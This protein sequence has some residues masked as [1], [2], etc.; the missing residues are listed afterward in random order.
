MD[1]ATSSESADAIA[2]K[3]EL[4]LQRLQQRRPAKQSRADTEQAKVREEELTE[5]LNRAKEQAD[6]G[7]VNEETIKALESFLSLEGCGWSAK[8]IQAALEMLRKTSV[9]VSGDGSQKSAFSFS[10]PKKPSTPSHRPRKKSSSVSSETSS[11]I[12]NAPSDNVIS[13]SNM[14]DETRLVAGENGNDIKLK[15]IK[16][17]K[18]SFAFR[19]STVHI[20]GLY[21][22][23][24]VFLPV[25]TSV[26]MS[27][28]QRSKI[29]ASA[30]QLR[31]HNSKE[32]RLHVGVRAA[33]I[34]ESCTGILMAPYRV[35]LNEEFIEAPPGEAWKH[36]NDFDW[37]AEGQSP[38]WVIAPEADWE[39][40]MLT[41]P[42]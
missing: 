14:S 4:L 15:E 12:E 29:F 41:V 36:P 30:Q 25:E 18:L 16:N 34:I 9:G 8:R 3:K 38:N 33:V 20:Q 39:T 2:K 11:V 5:L 28:C 27:D 21:D 1:E 7:V 22:S 19:P 26:L 31:I 6:S 10:A 35:K 32:L 42:Q 40:A 17:C 37:L 23:E 13:L 24:L